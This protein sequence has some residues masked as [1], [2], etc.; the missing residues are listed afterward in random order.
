M[1]QGNDDKIKVL[2]KRL[3]TVLSSDSQLAA[4]L[5]HNI[6][7]HMFQT[8]RCLDSGRKLCW[9]AF[10]STHNAIQLHVGGIVH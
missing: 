2:F 9:Q 3:G 4:T 8:N 1:R 5:F 6:L 10:I 7:N